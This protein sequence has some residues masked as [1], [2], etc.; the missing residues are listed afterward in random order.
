M[1]SAMP[2]RSVRVTQEEEED[3]DVGFSESGPRQVKEEK[4]KKNKD[5]LGPVDLGCI[6]SIRNTIR[7]LD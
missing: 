2:L 5:G 4:R 7:N 1:S 6:F 3:R